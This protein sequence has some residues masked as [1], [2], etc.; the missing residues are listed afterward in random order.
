MS[1]GILENV[2]AT[3]FPNV[4]RYFIIEKYLT[5]S[6]F[7]SSKKCSVLSSSTIFQQNLKNNLLEDSCTIFSF[8]YNSQTIL[9][10]FSF[11]YNTLVIFNV[12][13]TQLS[14]AK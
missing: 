11:K 1:L 10:S 8:K 3:K 9:N 4:V 6:N 13:G 14:I 7:S 12:S 2:Q 5:L